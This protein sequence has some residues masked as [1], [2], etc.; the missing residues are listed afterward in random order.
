L[1][2]KKHIDELFMNAHQW[3]TKER[4]ERLGKFVYSTFKSVSVL[5]SLQLKDSARLEKID[6]NMVRLFDMPEESMMRSWE[7]MQTTQRLIIEELTLLN[8]AIR[9][10][11]PD[12]FNTEEEK[13]REAMKEF[14]DGKTVV[15]DPNDA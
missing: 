7:A 3:V 14:L 8:R 1:N 11:K 6:R 13:A 2:W 9:T 4:E 5:E 12:A 15:I 10:L